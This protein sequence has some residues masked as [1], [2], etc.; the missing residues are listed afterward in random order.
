MDIERRSI[1]KIKRWR[2]PIVIDKDGV[3][4]AGH[5]RWLAA[6]QLGLRPRRK[7]KAIGGRDQQ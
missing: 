1:K 5:A 7:R 6:K 4:I 3:V 2:Q